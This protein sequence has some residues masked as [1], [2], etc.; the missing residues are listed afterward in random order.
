MADLV[1][2]DDVR[3][4]LDQ[5]TTSEHDVLLATFCAEVQGMVELYLGFTFSGYTSATTAVAY[6]RGTPWLVPPPHQAGSITSVTYEPAYGGTA[7][8]IVGW[9]EQPDGSLYFPGSWYGRLWYSGQRYVVTGNF[10]IGTTWPVEVKQVATE[11]VVNKFKEREKG[12]F[13]DVIGVEGAGGDTAIG[14]KGTFTKYQK[15][16]LD[17]TKF[18]YRPLVIA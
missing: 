5:I 11:I 15:M 6:G 9:A 4:V 3:D 16:I 8:N 7:T 18:K 12:M 14:Y 13:S 1:T 17:R 10:G 2:V